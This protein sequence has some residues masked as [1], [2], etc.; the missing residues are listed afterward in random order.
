[1]FL[2]LCGRYWLSEA[3]RGNGT[4][5]PFS[6]REMTK[7]IKVLGGERM[8]GITNYLEGCI[9]HMAVLRSKVK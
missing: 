7:D 3:A 2:Y 6:S 8:G 5:V 4:N 1:M 9:S